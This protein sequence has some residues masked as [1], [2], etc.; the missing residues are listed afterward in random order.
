[1]KKNTAM[2]PITWCQPLDA[3]ISS[4]RKFLIAVSIPV[5]CSSQSIIL[6]I[7]LDWSDLEFV[8]LDLYSKT[9]E[10]TRRRPAQDG[11]VHAEYRIVTGTHEFLRR[12]VPMDR[13]AQV[14]TDR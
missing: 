11:S 2:L 7:A 3:G 6:R 5:R 14:R 9:V 1:M 8:A 13:T 12:V 4:Y 10:R